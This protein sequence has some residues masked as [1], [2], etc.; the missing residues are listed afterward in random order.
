[1]ATHHAN[2]GEIVDPANVGCRFT[3]RAHQSYRQNRRD[4]ANKNCIARRKR[5]S[6]SQSSRADYRSMHSR[7][8]SNY[9]HGRHTRT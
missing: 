7:E 9:R 6:Y 8:N 2:P 5:N 1:M 3:Q 4:G